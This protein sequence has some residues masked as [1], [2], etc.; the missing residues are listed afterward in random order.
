MLPQARHLSIAIQRAAAEVYAF[1]SQPHN[2]PSWASGL[3]NVQRKADRWIAHGEDGDRY[4]R[5]A[6]RNQHGVLD[7]WLT[8]ADAT[9]IH[10][11]LRVIANAEGCEVLFTLFRRPG[12]SDEEFESD[13]DW[14]M[15]DLAALKRIMEAAT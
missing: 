15:R 4:L 13:A 2:L 12:M 7:H 14:V 1:A 6:E 3:G 8:L 10:V 11:P 9:E 5:F